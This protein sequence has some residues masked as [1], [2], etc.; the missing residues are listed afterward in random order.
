[1]S[2]LI[3]RRTL[4]KRSLAL[5]AALL[6]TERKVL[7]QPSPFSGDVPGATQ[8]ER[9]AM[10][11]IARAFMQQY[12][13]PGLS[14]AVGHAGKVVYED[15]FGWADR[16]KR[17]AVSASHLF[18]IASVTKPITS[19]A[20]LSLIEQGHLQLSDRV[21]GPGAIT[22]TDFRQPPYFPQV[23]QITVEHLLTHTSGGWTNDHADPMFMNLEMNHA[24]LIEWTLGNRPLD[25][26]PG[27]NYGY[28][29]FGY[30][31]LGRVIE[32][33]T[34]QP[35]APYV[36]K[37]VLERCGINDMAIAGNTLDQRRQGEVKYYGQ[38]D[39]PYSMNVARMDSHGGWI[40]RP[41]D[42]VQ[43][44][45][46]VHGFAVPPNILKP[47][48]IRTMTTATVANA[49]YAKGWQ[50]NRFQNWWHTGS[51]PGT[52]TI[53]VRT[54]SGFCWAA[55]TNTRRSNSPLAGDLDKLVWN[56]VSQV[57][58]WHV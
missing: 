16:E 21:F 20:I 42:L 51:L 2:P 4:L 7:A 14:I 6:P 30:C 18:R 38:G 1:M 36:R 34:R 48:T 10:S 49:G 31:V 12:D 9:A 13:V 43:F 45:M 58:S 22:G 19:V 24:Q 57:K 25:H 33:I 11:N 29:N 39:N 26:P 5:P 8:S 35:Y 32:N 44:L 53:A 17:E 40:A 3:D 50:V 37:A 23:E 52:T 41:A 28:S 55:F 47:Q 46:H 27:Q 15:A 56:M 54:H